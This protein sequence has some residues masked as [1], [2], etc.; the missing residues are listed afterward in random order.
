M[1]LNREPN[2]NLLYSSLYQDLLDTYDCQTIE[3]LEEHIKDKEPVSVFNDYL[4]CIGIIGFTNIILK[5]IKVL[6]V[7]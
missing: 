7:K 3:E 2:D 1:K 4:S 5:A 6:G